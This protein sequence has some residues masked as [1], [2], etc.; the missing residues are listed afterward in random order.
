[1]YWFSAKVGNMNSTAHILVVD[2]D[3]SILHFVCDALLMGGYEATT[4][5]NGA[6][7]LAAVEKV[8]PDLILLDLQMPIMDGWEFMK[9]YRRRP[10]EHAPVVITAG[11]G[12]LARRAAAVGADGYL[13]KP[14]DLN[15]LLDLVARFVGERR[16]V[17]AA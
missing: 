13:M 17:S 15:E 14:Y 11:G 2:D 8:H 12:G 10:G 1:M 3:R 4:A 7:A 6:D 9:V 5:R 16:A